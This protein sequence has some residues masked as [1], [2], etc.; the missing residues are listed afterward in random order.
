VRQLSIILW[1][2][3]SLLILK[4]VGDN[5]LILSQ[6]ESPLLAPAVFIMVLFIAVRN[7]DLIERFIGE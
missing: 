5:S 7:Y 1:V 2:I 4:I 6:V 3:E